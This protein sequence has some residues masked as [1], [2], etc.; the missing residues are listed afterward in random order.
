MRN[1]WSDPNHAS[2]VGQSQRQVQAPLDNKVNFDK[3]QYLCGYATGGNEY[4]SRP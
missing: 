3:V 4:G 1:V 2:G